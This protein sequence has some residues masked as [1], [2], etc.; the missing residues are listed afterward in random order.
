MDKIKI[1]I[2]SCLLGNKVRYDGQH[3]Q[4]HF[5]KD[6]LS[7]WCN[8]VP[9]C[10]EV[11]C[12]LSIP[13]ESIRLVGEVDNPKL[14]TTKTKIDHTKR[15]QSWIKEELDFLEKEELVGFIFK[16][17]SPSCGMRKV[18]I[19]N[20]A[21]YTISYAGIG[22]F[23]RAFME[24]FPDI[25][26]ED[27]GRLNDP[28]LRERFI[29]SIFVLQRWRDAVKSGDVKDLVLFHSKHKYTLMAHSPEKLRT[30]G[31]LIANSGKIDF[32]KLVK[33]YRKILFQ[34]LSLQKTRKKNYNVLL[35]MLG[36]FK[37]NLSAEEKA[38]LLSESKNY[39]EGLTPLVVP[40][41]LLRHYTKKYNENYLEDQQYLYPHPVELGLLNHV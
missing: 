37:K 25:P 4:D 38:E 39:L 31:K 5:L 7:Q 41:T 21:G 35:H 6:T 3:K 14:I 11:E 32:N 15:M 23:A 12:G 9:V 16:T 17:K 19:Y 33:E 24:R 18:K 22:M 40:L 36:Y 1:G 20:E 10:P 26:V 28:G 8:Y 30:L 13:R 27:E 34:L 2:S 29:E